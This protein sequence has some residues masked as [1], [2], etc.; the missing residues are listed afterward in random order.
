M[1]AWHSRCG[2]WFAR[3]GGSRPAS[4]SSRL[5]LGRNQRGCNIGP[6]VRVDVREEAAH[7][8]RK[9]RESTDRRRIRRGTGSSCTADTQH[10][11][12]D[13]T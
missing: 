10:T 5:D 8:A 3:R 4:C 1:S 6:R 12:P 13:V 11:G 7:S 2:Q 9:S